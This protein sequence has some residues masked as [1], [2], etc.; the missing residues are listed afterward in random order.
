MAA[1]IYRLYIDDNYIDYYF[2]EKHA[3][4]YAKPYEQEGCKILIIKEEI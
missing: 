3:L 1:Y 2:K 4:A